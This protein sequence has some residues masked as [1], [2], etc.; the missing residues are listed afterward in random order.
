MA[1]QLVR[2]MTMLVLIV[3]LAFVSAVA[4]ASGQT[5]LSGADIPFDFVAANRTLPAGQYDVVNGS[6]GQ[7]IVKMISAEKGGSVFTLTNAIIA[8]ERAEQSKLVFRR[9]GN[10]YF[11]SEIWVA[12][13]T[14]GRKLLKSREEKKMERELAS[15]PTKSHRTYERV[16]IALVRQ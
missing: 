9:Y 12:G 15:A 10:R 7:E 8:N 1:K 3:T 16:E 11:L 13:E 4:S 14:V 2:G 5:R 6:S